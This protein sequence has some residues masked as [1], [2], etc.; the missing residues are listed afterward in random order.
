MIDARLEVA[1]GPGMTIKPPSGIL[2]KSPSTV[3]SSSRLEISGM[4]TCMPCARAA[5]CMKGKYKFRFG[6]SEF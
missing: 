6:F 5:S 2:A 1:K 3:G 4:T